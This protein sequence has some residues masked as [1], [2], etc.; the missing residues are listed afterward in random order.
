MAQGTP[1]VIVSYQRLDETLS[2]ALAMGP[3]SVMQAARRPGAGSLESAEAPASDQEAARLMTA[4]AQALKHLQAAERVPGVLASPDDQFTSLLQSFLAEHSLQANKVDEVSTGGLE[5]KFDEHDILGWAGSLVTWIRKL[6]PHRWLTAPAVPDRLPE[7]LR[8]GILGDWGSGLYGA[9]HCARRIQDDPKGYGLLVHLGDVYYSGTE[10]EVADRFLALWPRTTAINRACNSNH[11]MYTGGHAYFRMTLKQFAQPASYFA[12]Q[13]THW[14]LVGLD[15]AYKEAQLAKDQVAW[16][17]RLLA[18]A[19]DRRVILFTH[20]QLFSW[21]D[22]TTGTIADQLASLLADRR[23]FAWYWGHEHRSVMYDPHPRWGLRGRCVGHGGYPYFRDQFTEG[24]VS[25]RG[26]QGTAWRQVAAKNMVPGGLILEG[27]NP[28][29]EQHA[30]Q[31]GPH[32]YMTL[33]FNGDR[34]NEIVHTPD[35]TIAYER[36]VAVTR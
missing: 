24:T 10:T 34:L 30:D 20:H 35:G 12:L 32:G 13:N 4:L 7:T 25:Q 33:E 17:Q 2:R 3:D 19:G 31:Y 23:L 15:S 26:P 28:Y 8:V 11:E 6:K 16:L 36:E 1:P 21:A 18:D 27:P 22:K 29:L 5:A 14:L 9:P